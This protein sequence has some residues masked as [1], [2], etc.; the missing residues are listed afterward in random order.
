M[1]LP[2]AQQRSCLSTLDAPATLAVQRQVRLGLPF[3]TVKKTPELP[4]LLSTNQTR[5]TGTT[6]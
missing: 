6:E 5:R 1:L 3:R 2:F 4:S